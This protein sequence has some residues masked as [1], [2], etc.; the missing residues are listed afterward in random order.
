[1]ETLIYENVKYKHE[2]DTENIKSIET[3]E[4]FGNLMER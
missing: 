4:L 1:M 2:L 3:D